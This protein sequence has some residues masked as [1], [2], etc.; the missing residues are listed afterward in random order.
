MVGG[1]GRGWVAWGEACSGEAVT[2]GA[3]VRVKAGGA[4]PLVLKASVRRLA[5]QG[6]RAPQGAVPAPLP[7]LG[8]PGGWLAGEVVAQ[9]PQA[10]QSLAVDSSGF[11]REA[12]LAL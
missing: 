11:L 4:E 12:T 3:F 10:V 7:Q 5:A 9:T 1:A 8:G 6:L 2:E